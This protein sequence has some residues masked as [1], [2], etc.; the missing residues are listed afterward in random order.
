MS[1]NNR[2][3]D[4]I[5]AVWNILGGEEG[6]DALINGELVISRPTKVWKTWMTLRLGTFKNVEEIRQ[7]LKAG[8]NNINDWTNNILGKPAFTVSE[9]EQDVELVNVSVRELGFKKG[10]SYTDICERAQELGLDL[11]HVEVGP[12]LRLQWKDQPKGMFIVVGINTVVENGLFDV[13]RLECDDN[14][15]RYLDAVYGRADVEWNADI[16]FIF[17][18]RSS[19]T[20]K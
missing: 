4:R 8:G 6:V 12:Q 17:V 9:T 15:M 3:V 19:I 1:K 20:S 14:G 11:C 18:R 7:A 5:Q 13:F 16:C 2:T 10:A